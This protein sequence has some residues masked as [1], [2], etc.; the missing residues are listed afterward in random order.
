MSIIDPNDIRDNVKYLTE[1][2]KVQTHIKSLTNDQIVTFFDDYVRYDEITQIR[3]EAV[4]EGLND[5]E[6]ILK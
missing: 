4:E 3:N 5:L 1:N 6:Q 2:E